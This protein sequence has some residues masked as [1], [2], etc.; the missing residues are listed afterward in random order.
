QRPS[1]DGSAL[2]FAAGMMRKGLVSLLPLTLLLSMA[3]GACAG[4]PNA[5]KLA[6]VA[7]GDKYAGQQQYAEAIIEYRKAVQVDPNFGK[8]RLKLASSY[9]A[10]GDGPN[11]LR[12]YARAADLMPDNA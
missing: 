1:F 6:S 10:V 5:R 8:A 12:E 4:D 9:A 2:A 11:A 7:R 3:L